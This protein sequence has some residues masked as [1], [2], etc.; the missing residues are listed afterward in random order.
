[1]ITHDS[2]MINRQQMVFALQ[3]TYVDRSV[4]QVSHGSEERRDADQSGPSGSV[5]YF[6][7]FCILYYDA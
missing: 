4:I 7:V 5:I 6:R 3:P 1:M 2:D